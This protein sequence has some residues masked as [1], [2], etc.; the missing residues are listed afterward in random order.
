M[1]LPNWTRGLY[2]TREV[3]AVIITNR[4]LTLML[5]P[6]IAGRFHCPR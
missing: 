1:A 2:S 5:I 6:L 3:C 4:F